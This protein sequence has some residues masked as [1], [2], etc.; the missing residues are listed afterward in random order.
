[1]AQ[2]PNPKQQ[3]SWVMNPSVGGKKA[4]TG[5]SMRTYDQ[6]TSSMRTN[7]MVRGL[8]ELSNQLGM[9]V[10]ASTQL[11]CTVVNDVEKCKHQNSI[12][13]SG[14]NK[15]T[16]TAKAWWKDPYSGELFVWMVLD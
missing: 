2:Q 15:V 9:Q 3:P 11:D 6:K 10:G 16:A 14:S 8:A 12:T 5:S 13:T 1:M 7:A 4:A